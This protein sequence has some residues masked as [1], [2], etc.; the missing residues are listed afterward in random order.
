MS[1]GWS[2]SIADI[3][4]VQLELL[5]SYTTLQSLLLLLRRT[6]E[7][8]VELSDVPAIS[9]DGDDIRGSTDDALS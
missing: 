3:P 7:Q 2:L 9:G 4:P 1:P 5:L 8:S 6:S